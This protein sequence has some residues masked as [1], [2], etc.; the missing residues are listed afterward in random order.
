MKELF[1]SGSATFAPQDTQHNSVGG[2]FKRTTAE[3]YCSYCCSIDWLWG[4]CRC[5]MLCSRLALPVELRHPVRRYF[6]RRYCKTGSN[7]CR[8]TTKEVQQAT[9]RCGTTGLRHCCIRCQVQQQ[10]YCCF[11]GDRSRHAGCRKICRAKS[12]WHRITSLS[13]SET[14]IYSEF[15]ASLQ[16]L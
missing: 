6:G 12:A 8:K 9:Q 2:E 16:Q 3:T 4:S 10:Q 1:V 11:A 7:R 5:C 15:R 14:F 13:Q